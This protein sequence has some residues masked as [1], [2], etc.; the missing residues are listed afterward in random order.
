MEW[1]IETALARVKAVLKEARR[2]QHAV[3]VLNFDQETICPPAAMEEQGETIAF[4]GNQSFRL[5]KQEDFIQAANDLYDHRE[6]LEPL[7]RAMAESLRRT[8]DKTKNLTP[9]LE[10]AHALVYQKG[11]VDWLKAKEQGAFDLFAPSLKAVRAAQLEE[12]ELRENRLPDTYDEMLSDYERGITRADL[13]KC[14]DACK[15]RLIPLL[16]RIQASP[17]QIRTDF[18]SRTVTDESQK[19]MA[20]YLL[21]TIGFDFNRGTFATTEHPFTAG[22]ARDDVRVTTHY[23]PD[24]FASNMYSIIHEGGHAL[25]E[26]LTPGAHYDHFISGD[27]TMGQHES[28]SRFYENI[29]GRSEA[30]VHLIYPNV[31]EI[32]PE[33][34]AD[35]TERELYEALNG[36]RPSLIRTEADEF[37]YTFHIIIRYEMEKMIVDGTAALED[38]PRIWNE[39]YREYLGVTPEN[40]REGILQDVHW[41]S[42]FGYFPT[43]ALGNLYN[44]MYYNRRNEDFDVPAAVGAGDFG[45]INGWMR[46][47][48]FQK[49]DVLSPKQ[50]LREVTG[51]ELT[52]EDFLDYLEEKYSRLYELN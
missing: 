15:A 49:A 19:K 32:F 47:H 3:S 35:V 52:T 21:H 41:S 29:I 20:E 44:A 31:C 39:K 42:G 14:F 11:F 16:R 34:M 37:T 17:K 30:F 13:D 43:Y 45:K 2:Y 8:Y 33:V 4:L 10:H 6:E 26:Q 28:V 50:W 24:Q 18:L 46:E 51:R 48:V 5:T 1:N 25:F 36:V 9:E 40:H 22:L 23:Y 38:L 12:I 27:K 7:D